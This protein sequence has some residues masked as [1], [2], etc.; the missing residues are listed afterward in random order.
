VQYWPSGAIRELTFGNG[1]QESASSL[2]QRMRPTRWISGPLN[3]TY[4]YDRVGN[5]T[6]ITDTRLDFSSDFEYDPLDR[7]WRV[8]GFGAREF[9]YDDYGNRLTKVRRLHARR[10]QLRPCRDIS[11]YIDHGPD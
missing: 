10:L 7:L 3:L 5:V 9:S 8:T 4:G 11:P 1:R 2:D 6:R